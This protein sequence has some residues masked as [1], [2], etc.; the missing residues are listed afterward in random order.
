MLEPNRNG[1]LI[2]MTGIVKRFPGVLA[3]D[4][5]DFELRPGEVHAL[6]GANGAGKSTLIK[7]LS[8]VYHKDEG[9]VQLRGESVDIRD[10]R[11]S[12]SLGIATIYQ[13]YN[14]VPDLSVAENVS[15]GHIP[16]GKSFLTRFLINRREMNRTTDRIL[17]NLQVDISPNTPVR[18][19]GVAKQQMVEIAKALSLASEIY[20][21]D[22]PTAALSPKEIEELFRVVRQMKESGSS[23][24]Y[25]SH[26]LEEVGEIADRVTVM[27]DGR[28][29]D[30]LKAKDASMDRLVKL[31]VG[32]SVA[33]GNPRPPCAPGAKLLQVE[34]LSRKGV[35]EDVNLDICAGEIVGLAGLMGSGRT[36]VARAIFGADRADKGQVCVSGKPARIKSPNHAVRQGIC[37]LPEDR[38]GLGLVLCASVRDNIILASLSRFSRLRFRGKGI[39]LDYKRIR[40]E[41]MERIQSLDIKTPRIQQLVETLSGGN[42]QKVV[43]ARW[44]CS[45]ARVFLF[46]EPTRGIDVGAKSEIYGLVRTLAEDGAGILIISSEVEELVDVCDRVYVLR[47]GRIVNELDRESISK[48]AILAAALTGSAEEH[49]E[50]L[51][52]CMEDPS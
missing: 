5:V 17:R 30:T 15:L 23:V 9:D 25:I 35:F 44:L 50:Q 4:H 27:R 45:S 47:Q 24:I 14:L 6:L 12:Q 7:I 31:M 43:I 34:G 51:R 32:R 52:N 22:E 33:R 2:N 19:L 10:P 1:V 38:K 20:I 37:Y 40:K 18:R 49:G 29:E 42:Q 36:E 13:E 11:H 26:R 3:L 8:G 21:M 39:I 48:E 41:V 16:I 28:R 46:D